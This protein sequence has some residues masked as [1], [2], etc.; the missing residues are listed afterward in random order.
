MPSRGAFPSAYNPIIRSLGGEKP[1]QGSRVLAHQSW[2]SSRVESPARLVWQGEG[3][4]KGTA[5][6][7]WSAADN[8]LW[9]V[10]GFARRW[11]VRELARRAGEKFAHSGH[12]R[13]GLACEQQCDRDPFSLL[14]RHKSE[15]RS[16]HARMDNVEDGAWLPRDWP[17]GSDVWHRHRAESGCCSATEELQ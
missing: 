4:A 13:D 3:E 14:Q 8:S 2:R 5:T 16:R 15:E 12:Q 10:D 17:S 1:F 9:W 11:L 6:D 7:R